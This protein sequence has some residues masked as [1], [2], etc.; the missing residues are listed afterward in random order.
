MGEFEDRAR[1]VIKGLQEIPR[2]DFKTLYREELPDVT[3]VPDDTDPIRLSEILA[4]IEG[5]V[6][7]KIDDLGE[8]SGRLAGRQLDEG[9][10][11]Q[12]ESGIDRIGLDILAFYKSIH[13]Q[14]APPFAGQWGIFLLESGILTIAEDLDDFEPGI[15]SSTELRNLA[16]GFLLAHETFHFRVDAWAIQL[17]A[18][19]NLALYKAYIENIY[20]PLHPHVWLVEESLANNLAHKW[21]AAHGIT[22]F[23]KWFI[24]RQ[25]GAYRRFGER[26]TRSDDGALIRRGVLCAQLRY[27]Q[28]PL[29]AVAAI[30]APFEPWMRDL[31]RLKTRVAIVDIKHC[32]VYLVRDDNLSQVLPRPFL[33]GPSRREARDF[34][35]RYLRGHKIRKTDHTLYQIDNGSIVKFPN[36]HKGV[37]R[38]RGYEFDNILK[39]AGMSKPLYDRERA[40]TRSWRRNVPRDSPLPPLI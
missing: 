26:M 10:R 22:A 15:Y 30:G 5:P 29:Q 19:S 1:S 16:S 23:S 2:E 28:D 20:R 14:D 6:L 7:D 35:Q 11:G 34:V 25:P 12:I 37:D 27:P 38:L 18:S 31:S 33:S 17:E 40:R 36:I 9:D 24:S 39:H 4:R 3:R 13:F 32:P 21:A 8:I